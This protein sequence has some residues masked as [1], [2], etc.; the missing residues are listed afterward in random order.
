MAFDR[1]S[2]KVQYL[3]QIKLLVTAAKN[4]KTLAITGSTLKTNVN[5]FRTIESTSAPIMPTIANRKNR[6]LS[7]GLL[8]IVTRDSIP[9]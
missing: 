9:L 6:D 7:C 3:F 2:G 8:S 4:E 1:E 5:K